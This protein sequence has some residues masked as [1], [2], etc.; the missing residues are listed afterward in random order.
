MSER[1][2][3][4]FGNQKT[5]Y[6]KSVWFNGS[7]ALKKGR[8]VCYDID[9]AGTGTGETATDPW[10]RRGRV[11]ALPSTA[12]NLA[13][14]G[15]TTQAYTAKTGGQTIT[16]F[17][18]GSICE[19]QVGIASTIYSQA[20]GTFHTCS[21]NSADAG[22]FTLQGLPGRGTAMALE[23]QADAAGGNIAM[24]S[25]AVSFAGASTTAWVSPSLTIT[26]TA[27]GTNCG[28]GDDDID[29]TEYRVIVL[30]GADN[31]AG[32][33]A[34]TGELAVQGDYPV[35]TA[36]TADTITI[37]TDIGD[38][39]LT[40]Y[41][42]KNTYSCVLCKL[43][44]GPESGLQEVL[45]PQDA[46]AVQSM[47]GGTTILCGGY[48]MAAASTATLADGMNNGLRKA[49]AGLG[50][51]TTAGYVVTAANAID[52]DGGAAG[53]ITLDAAGEYIVL[54]FNGSFYPGSTAGVWHVIGVAGTTRA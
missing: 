16:I 30:G 19:V 52:D 14:A 15:V 3:A 29:P 17:E 12:N 47:V 34:T 8:G 54:E 32:G 51:L 53:T 48:T 49:Y 26:A 6:K 11:V 31:A 9:T 7:T 39:D 24:S 35:V 13:F 5:E 2:L 23:T 10:G 43:L 28:Y 37:A 22:A 42:V 33:D 36:P 41:V 45:S 25:A 46:V 1:N 50:T 44:D 27:V 21:V 18:P 20:A 40:F 38:V 4:L